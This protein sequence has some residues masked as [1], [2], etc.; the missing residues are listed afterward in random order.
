M[1]YAVVWSGDGPAIYAGRLELDDRGLVLA[2]LAPQ[3]RE[4][5][6]R[7]FYDELR[8]VHVER[9]PEARLAGRPT[10][11]AECRNGVRIRV[12]LVDGTGSLLE[13]ADRISTAR[14]R[15]AA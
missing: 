9:R 14:A 3:A 2:G 6:R 13:V 8:E 4:S 12:A 7:I 10:L 5:R 11:F 1:T 15:A